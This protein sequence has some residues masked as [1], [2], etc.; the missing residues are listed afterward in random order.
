MEGVQII[1]LVLERILTLSSFQHWDHLLVIFQYAH[2]LL[3]VLSLWSLCQSS[4]T[5]CQAWV[6]AFLNPQSTF[7][8]STWWEK[9][10]RLEYVFS[11]CTPAF[12]IRKVNVNYARYI[13]GE[14]IDWNM[15]QSLKCV[16]VIILESGRIG[17][18]WVLLACLLWKKL[19]EEIREEGK[20]S[21][22][23]QIIHFAEESDW[24]LLI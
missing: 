11:A 13:F 19:W 20:L 15:N 3:C 10:V 22:P 21:S 18:F 17:Y 16:S 5:H 14:I 4:I 23:R 1:Q 8:L 6:P 9:N 2:I 24:L 7:R 12:G